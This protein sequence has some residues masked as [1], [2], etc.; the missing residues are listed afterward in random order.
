MLF[1][2]LTHFKILRIKFH[3]Q[4]TPSPDMHTIY[5]NKGRVWSQD[6]YGYWPVHQGIGVQAPREGVRKDISLLHTIQSGSVAHPV[7]AGALPLEVKQ[8]GHEADHSPPSSI[9]EP[10]LHSPIHLH[11]VVLN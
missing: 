11:G 5:S 9:K 3:K 2:F 4:S 1:S 7:T 8:L 6:N 10:Y